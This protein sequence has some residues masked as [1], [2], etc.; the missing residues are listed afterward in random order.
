MR[1]YDEWLLYNNT[2]TNFDNICFATRRLKNNISP[3]LDGIPNEAIKIIVSKQPDTI[4]KLLNKCLNK[5]TFPIV[6]KKVRLFLL[7]KG[8]KPLNY[9]SSYRPLCLMDSTAKLFEKII[10]NRLRCILETYNGLDNNQFGFRAGRSTTDALKLI[11]DIEKRAGTYSKI[12]LLTL[13]I[14]NAFNSASWEK[15]LDAMCAK[16]LPLYLCR[17]INSYPTDR[18]L[19]I[20]I[21]SK[22]TDVELSSGVLQSSVLGPTLWNLLYDS[23]FH[24]DFLRR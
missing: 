20:N 10:D 7:K 18:T 13:D 22:Y 3:G 8:D 11:M 21:N 4:L 1:H 15:I 6:W 17:I 24:R 16:D 9:P 2:S 14:K 12:G 5:G 23:L 19:S